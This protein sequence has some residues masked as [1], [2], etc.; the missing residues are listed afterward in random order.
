VIEL[1]RQGKALT[2]A[3]E[4]WLLAFEDAGVKRYTFWPSD[5]LSGEIEA[6]LR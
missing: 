3:Q 5:L 2:E 1:K 4:D 6:V